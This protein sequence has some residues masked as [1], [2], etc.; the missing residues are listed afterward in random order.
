MLLVHTQRHKSLGGAMTLGK[1][2]NSQVSLY[3]ECAQDKKSFYPGPFISR[4]VLF[5]FLDACVFAFSGN[6]R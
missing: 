6:F 3:P 2:L 5:F 4:F 1:H